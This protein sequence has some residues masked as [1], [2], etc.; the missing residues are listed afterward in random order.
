[1]L[2]FTMAAMT[3]T[4]A[5]LAA[6]PAM[7]KDLRG[8][9]FIT[10]LNGNTLTGKLPDGKPFNLYFLPG[11]QASYQE[12]AGQTH[13]GT[14]KLDENGDVCVQWAPGGQ[15]AN[16]CFQVSLDGDKVTW[17]NMDGTH[18]GGLLGGVEP[19]TMSK[20]Q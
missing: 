14:W 11:G 2:K 15:M 12:T 5:A 7:A 18:Q 16:G 6:Q 9:A 20:G 4:A 8:D 13:F 19:L 1:M 3:L 10:A 17:S